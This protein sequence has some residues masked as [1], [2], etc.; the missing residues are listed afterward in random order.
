MREYLTTLGLDL[1]LVNLLGYSPDFNAD[2]VI[3]VWAREEATGNL[4]L[5]SMVAVQCCQFSGNASLLAG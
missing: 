1:G 4:C 5:G 3:W 2:E